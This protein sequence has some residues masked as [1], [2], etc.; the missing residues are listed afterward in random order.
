LI[1]AQDK[2]SLGSMEINTVKV[3]IGKDAQLKRKRFYLFKGSLDFNKDLIEK[4][5]TNELVSRDCFYS[6]MKSS[7]EFICWLKKEN[8]DSPYCR[9]I[10][11]TDIGLVPEFKTAFDKGLRQFGKNRSKIALDWLTT[12][13]PPILTNGFYERKETLLE[14]LLGKLRPEQSTLTDND[15]LQ[16]LFIDIPTNL[17]ET[18]STYLISNLLP[19]EIG[20]K[21]YIWACEIEVKANKQVKL[22]LSLPKETEENTRTENCEVIVK[23]LPQCSTEGCKQ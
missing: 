3:K 17:P 18:G 14:N 13:L 11:Q 12:N 20:S 22:K 5:K 2:P 19:V 21:S 8:C 7:P 16:A 10:N 4:F 1:V 6:Q 9:Q 23:T 15:G